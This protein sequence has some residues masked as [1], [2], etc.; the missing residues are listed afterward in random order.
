[1]TEKSSIGGG[2][3]R[4]TEHHSNGSSTDK[5]YVKGECVAITD[6]DAN[7][8]SHS[9]EVGHGLFGPFKGERKD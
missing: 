5:D 4:V 2:G 3:T 9:H 1:M 6:H 8:K 7:G